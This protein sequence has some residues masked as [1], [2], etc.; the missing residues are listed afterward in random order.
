MIFNRTRIYILTAIVLVLSAL[1]ISFVV[2]NQLES[3]SWSLAPIIPAIFPAMAAIMTILRQYFDGHEG[4][5]TDQSEAK[6]SSSTASGQASVTAG[7]DIDVSTI[8][9]AGNVNIYRSPTSDTADFSNSAKKYHPLLVTLTRTNKTITRVIQ[10][11]QRLKED[12]LIR[13]TLP[14]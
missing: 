3:S 9:S 6:N 8:A 1:I 14:K 10:F 13:L 12:R 7:R 4:D 5:S 2:S 11:T